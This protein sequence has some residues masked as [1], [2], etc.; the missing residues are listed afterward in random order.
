MH[1]GKMMK[2][3]LAVLLILTAVGLWAVSKTDLNGTLINDVL[4]IWFLILVFIM[5]LFNKKKNDLYN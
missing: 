2:K 4:G 1:R 3:V 5:L